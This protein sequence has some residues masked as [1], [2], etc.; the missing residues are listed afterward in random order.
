MQTVFTQNEPM[1][2]HTETPLPAMDWGFTENQRSAGEMPCGCQG[3][4]PTGN[5][6]RET[7]ETPLPVPNW[8]Y[9]K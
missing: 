9:P 7:P 8:G 5:A 2:V 1:S 3:E 6:Q 4:N